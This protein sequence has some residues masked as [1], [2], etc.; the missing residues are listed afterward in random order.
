MISNKNKSSLVWFLTE[1][2][3]IQVWWAKSTILKSNRLEISLDDVSSFH[4]DSN[5][6]NR[7]LFWVKVNNPFLILANKKNMMV[8]SSFWMFK[9]YIWIQIL[10]KNIW[11]PDLLK[12]RISGQ[13][14]TIL[15]INEFLAETFQNLKRLNQLRR[16][17]K[18][19]RSKS[20]RNSL[21]ERILQKYRQVPNRAVEF[22]KSWFQVRI[23]GRRHL[24]FTQT[25]LRKR[26]S[27]RI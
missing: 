18:W 3:S 4:Q 20:H 17:K 16:V 6:W 12:K 27:V 7:T 23:K 14:K 9:K 22:S 21:K 15:I 26:K 13:V 11:L 19:K 1:N 5:L 10:T 2:K 24:E 8:S 25:N